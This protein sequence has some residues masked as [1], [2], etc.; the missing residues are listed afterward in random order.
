MTAKAKRKIRR[1]SYHALAFGMLLAVLSLGALRAPGVYMRTY[2][3]L[4]DFALSFLYLFDVPVTP[5]VGTL[6]QE[7]AEGFPRAWSDLVLLLEDLSARFISPAN[8]AGYMTFLGKFLLG[9]LMALTVFSLVVVLPY[10][11][12]LFV[13]LRAYNQRTAQL[14]RPLAAFLTVYQRAIL[15]VKHYVKG[16]RRFFKKNRV[17]PVLLIVLTLFFL[18]VFNI[19]VEFFAWYYTF[20]FAGLG[21]QA[22]KLLYDVTIAIAFLPWWLWLPLLLYL[23]DKWR[24]Y[25]GLLKLRQSEEKFRDFIKGLAIAT[26]VTAPMRE[27]KTT[28][29]TA[30]VLSYDKIFREQAHDC[31]RE[32]DLKFPNFPWLALQN[33]LQKE[34][35]WHRV[36]NL[37]TARAWATDL[38][39]IHAAAKGPTARTHYEKRLEK[40]YGIPL[41]GYLLLGYNT[42][43]WP[44]TYDR[45]LGAEHIYDAIHDYAQLFFIY[46]APSVSVS[47]FSIRFDADRETKGNDVRWKDDFFKKDPTPADKALYSHIVHYDMMRLGKKVDPDDEYKNAFEF[48]VASFTELAKE[49]GNQYDRNGLKAD[50]DE[51]NILNDLFNVNFKMSGHAAEV[52]YH[53]F[54]RYISD[55]QRANSLNADL[56][57][58]MDIIQL[59]QKSK[60]K[61]LMPFFAIEEAA[62]LLSQKILG[63]LFDV[64]RYNHG[65]TSLS[66][67]ILHNVVQKKI[68][69]HYQRIRSIY[70]GYTVQV[71]VQDGAQLEEKRKERLF[72]SERKVYADRFRTDN[73][74]DYYNQKALRSKTG[75]NDIP[76]YGSTRQTMDE[77]G[78]QGAYLFR[79]LDKY[80]IDDDP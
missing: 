26:L 69:D 60:E 71:Y 50:A 7:L 2:E 37:A 43:L 66:L 62:Y 49:R 24:H 46:I 35:Q 68:F 38:C 41:N 22:V 79:K 33:A 44:L 70:G 19:T 34:I 52:Y 75:I 40:L 17:Y 61:I 9:I 53:T 8:L 78:Q 1:I 80:F 10:G 3:A 11:I 13:D 47:N 65:D 32:I 73:F 12:F 30:M 39:R 25:R 18:N 59:S 15:P 56:K 55:E 6:P 63:K 76:T 72:M 67:W 77:N 48:G 28:F 51:A 16:F 23:L 14:T 64:S 4:R 20:D 42:D 27:G 57:E 58:P 74:K 45:G 21:M 54:I 5:T 29:V 36:Y 31:M